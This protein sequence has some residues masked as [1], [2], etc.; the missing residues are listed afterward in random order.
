MSTANTIRELTEK[1]LQINQTS[2]SPDQTLT[3]GE[4]LPD[5]TD[6]TLPGEKTQESRQEANDKKT[7]TISYGGNEAD[8]Y[9]P[10]KGKFEI[11]EGD[12]TDFLFKE[13]FLAGLNK[14]GD[15]IFGYAGGLLYKAGRAVGKDTWSLIKDVREE[16]K[17][18]RTNANQ[19]QQS[20]RT[21]EGYETLCL[22]DENVHDRAEKVTSCGNIRRFYE[23]QRG[24]NKKLLTA[25]KNNRD[26]PLD[27]IVNAHMNQYGG[28]D[29]DKIL[30]K[31]QNEENGGFKTFLQNLKDGKIKDTDVPPYIQAAILTE[32][33]NTPDTWYKQY[34]NTNHLTELKENDRAAYLYE[35][36]L[37]LSGKQY[38][39]RD[40]DEV[41]KAQYPQS[42]GEYAPSVNQ[43]FQ[44]LQKGQALEVLT[45]QLTFAQMM[46]KQMNNPDYFK[47]ENT[48]SLYDEVYQE[49]QRS[50]LEYH[51]NLRKEINKEISNEKLTILAGVSLNEEEEEKITKEISFILDADNDETN[52]GNKEQREEI[53]EAISELKSRLGNVP[54][55][56]LDKLS[57]A[58]KELRDQNI[59]GETITQFMLEKYILDQEAQKRFQA[60]E[61]Q[62]QNA[63]ARASET[64]QTQ[65]EN[66][67]FKPEGTPERNEALKEA[68][69]ILKKYG[70]E[71]QKNRD[72][73]E[74][75]QREEQQTADQKKKQETSREEEKEGIRDALMADPDKINKLNTDLRN[76]NMEI[77]VITGQQKSNKEARDR[78]NRALQKMG[79]GKEEINEYVQNETNGQTGENDKNKLTKE[80]ANAVM[81]GKIGNVSNP[82]L[83][84]YTQIAQKIMNKRTN[85]N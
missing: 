46:D 52:P 80:E 61:E 21:L 47:G 72:R 17:T 20:L 75:E 81:E 62:L 50:V 74:E 18:K 69:D 78:L 31:I 5:F 13:I 42:T 45:H 6:F 26:I 63:A 44:T 53:L 49:V 4:K 79:I 48:A 25:I 76:I 85:T 8:I 77:D 15:E 65:M 71:E 57:P 1:K 30:Q 23:R 55:E 67:K 2:S 27:T 9:D 14:A 35:A 28:Y 16:I 39:Y 34:D 60:Q 24:L 66:K 82:Q 84:K 41:I 12:I 64:I 51:D 83:Q 54:E 73:Q 10:E 22:I 70:N 32:A 3:V 11:K 59:N 56:D 40:Y 37:Y 36:E 33:A 58:E 43:I 7:P 38:V 68:E 29:V 19:Q